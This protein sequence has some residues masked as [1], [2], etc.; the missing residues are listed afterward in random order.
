MRDYLKMIQKYGFRLALVSLVTLTMQACS[1][2]YGENGL[3]HDS[4]NDFAK[5]QA[6]KELKAPPE[7]SPFKPDNLFVIPQLPEASEKAP[8]GDALDMRPPALVLATAE[9]VQPLQE[10]KEPSAVITLNFNELQSELKVFLEQSNIKIR[11]EDEAT[12][13][14]QTDWVET[15]EIGWFSHWVMWEDTLS[16]RWAYRIQISPGERPNEQ[17][18]TVVAT[19]A[20]RQERSGDWKPSELTRRHSTIM[21]NRILG[22]H[23]D[24]QAEEARK[25]IL[26][27]RAGINVELWEDDSGMTGLLASAAFDNAWEA[28][29]AVFTGLGFELEDKDTT[30]HL[31]YFRLN[32]SE[33]GGFWSNLFSW[34]TKSEDEVRK[35]LEPGEYLVQLT[36]VGQSTGIVMTKADGDAIKKTKLTA[37]FPTLSAAFL[38]RRPASLL[39]RR[40]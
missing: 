8:V 37:L 24:V 31:Y 35:H 12:H 30:K 10:T 11:S 1:W 5:A 18:V 33:S 34:G 39:E 2:L 32:E 13:T 9:G 4:Q 29:P 20:N 25:R 23:D 3:I 27:A 26:A 38:E 6:E 40:N 22:Y 28:T 21:L 14:V 7:L 16:Y 19:D 15:E 36:E 17:I